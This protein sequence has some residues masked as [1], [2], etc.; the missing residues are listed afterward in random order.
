MSL[1][2]INPATGEQLHE[3]QEHS[4]SEIDQI[5]NVSQAAYQTWHGTSFQ[6][7]TAALRQ[8]AVRLGESSEELAYL[9]TSEMGKPIRQARAEVEKCAWV[10]NFYA[11]NGPD[12]L[13]PLPVETSASRS[14]VRFDPI[15]SVLAVMPWNFPFWQVFRAAAP[16]IMAGNAVVLKHASNVSGCSL[17][18]EQLFETELLPHGL[19]RSLLISS[20]GV[21]GVIEDQR[22]AAVTVTGSEAAGRAVA[23]AAGHSL[24]KSV[25]ELGGA[26]PFIVLADA[27]IDN[28][29][30]HAAI[31]RTQ[32][33]GQSCIAAKRFLVCERVVQEFET[34]FV[35]EMEA[36]TT[37][38]PTAEDTDIGPLARQDLVD[39]LHRQV[40]ESVAGGAKIL[41]GGAP[42]DGL[43]CFYPP[44][45][46]SEVSPGMPAFDEELFGPVAAVTAVR[47]ADHAVELA[48][49]SRFGLGASL[50]TSDTR[51]AEALA[52]RIESGAVFINEFTKSDPRLPF[53]GVKASGYGRELSDFGIREFTNIKTVWVS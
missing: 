34:A 28:A 37:G 10:L 27:D 15:G 29:A 9:M 45:V 38:N 6:D 46:L 26:D 35:R 44:T 52:R 3:Y 13:S 42:L 24:K 51:T 22:I 32:N 14:Y 25:L 41:T 17:A 43:D 31:A 11:D 19:F 50:W 20:S 47:D 48:N 7:R 53:G 21:R 39:E 4:D 16:A 33:S 49:Q 1:L 12:F 23:A 18:I 40:S 8:I 5:L 30:R 36:L 2:S